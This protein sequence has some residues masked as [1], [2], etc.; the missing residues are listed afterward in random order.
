[1]QIPEIG[2]TAV[3]SAQR[4]SNAVMFCEIISVGASAV[5]IPP[6][7]VLWRGAENDMHATNAPANASASSPEE[8]ESQTPPRSASE[9]TSD[10]NSIGFLLNCPSENDFIREFPQS[11]IRSPSSKPE[12][13]AAMPAGKGYGVSVPAPGS[14]SVLQQYGH[15]IQENNIDV[16]LNRLEFQHFEQETSNWQRPNEHTILWSGPD[17][18][19]LDRRL[20]DQRAFDIREKLKY[21]AA[22]QSSPQLP[23]KENSDAIELITADSIASFIKLY[24]RHWHKHAPMVHE[25]TFNPCTAAIPLV[26]SL[27][28]LGGMYSGDSKDVAQLKLL[29]DTIESYIFSIPGLSDEYDMPGRVYVKHGENASPEWQQY[30]LQELQG[31]YLMIVLQYWTGNTIARTRVRQQR[32]PKIVHIFHILD[33]LTA[34]HSPT[35]LIS[36]Q[37]SFRAWIRKESFIRTATLAVML[38]HAFGIFNNVSPHF[39][40]AEIDL[41]FP[42]DD[43]SFQISNFDEMVANS[44]IPRLGMKI[45][46]AFLILFSQ[47]DDDLGVLRRGNLTALD[48]QM[49]IHFLYTHV[50]AST[51]SNPLAALP[52]TNIQA[53][54]APFYLAMRNWMVLWE[55]IK[56]NAGEEEWNKLGFQRT[57]ESYYDA[58][59]SILDVFERREGQFPPI[60]SDCEKGSHLKRLLS[61]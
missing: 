16:F 33:V 29:L 15:M 31:A 35:S 24:F 61:F 43:R 2:L 27:L 14:A 53:L 20:L 13:F 48:L 57:A 3:N 40:W 37:T 30:Q 41:P 55:E 46:D 32:F 39:Q 54:T 7:R 60:P 11:S 47:E 23:S 56:A 50:W 17:A 51:F 10:R 1:M 22:V 44:A 36:D 45:K 59:R 38:D 34:Q 21:M 58:V 8:Q 42:S 49:L 28:S 9:M 6:F 26:L 12:M 52:I 5:V 18:L 19:F 4:P 25:A